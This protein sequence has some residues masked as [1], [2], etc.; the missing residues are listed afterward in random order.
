[1]DASLRVRM[2]RL[3]EAID[4]AIGRHWVPAGGGVTLRH[5]RARVA[6]V[7]RRVHRLDR[8]ESY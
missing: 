7:W 4:C 8:I 6:I 3:C 5:G 2:A 1:M